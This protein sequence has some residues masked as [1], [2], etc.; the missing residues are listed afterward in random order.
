M[1]KKYN[2]LIKYLSNQ[3]KPL[4]STEISNALDISSRSVKNYVGDINALYHNKIILSSRNG[5]TINPKISL[6]LLLNKKKTIFLKLMKI[7]L[8]ILLNS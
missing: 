6:N 2:D 3:N 4:T 1:K 7:D 5:Y 8:F